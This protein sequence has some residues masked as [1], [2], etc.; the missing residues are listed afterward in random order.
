MI[1][2]RIFRRDGRP[3]YEAQWEDPTSGRK[4]TRTTGTPNRR[5]AE[6]FAAKLQL[7]L[8]SG[9]Y[10]DP[11][12]TGW[13]D[14]QALYKLEVFPAQAASTRRKM[15]DTFSAITRTIN[16]LRL[17][18]I[19][20]DQIALLCNALRLAGRAEYTIKGH[21][22]NIRRF[23]RWAVRRKLIQHMPTFDVP[24]K[25]VPQMKGRAPTTE[26]FDRLI[27][28]VPKVVGNDVA[29]AWQRMLRGLWLSGLRLSEALS[30]HWTDDSRLA[31]DLSGKS[32][33]FRIQ[34]GAEKGRKFRL[35]PMTPDFHAFLMETPEA[36]RHGYVFNPTGIRLDQR[37]SM[38]WASK[39]IVEI[40]QKANVKV[41]EKRGG[42]IKFVSSHDL[43]RAFGFRW[44][45]RV[46]AP[47]LML[48]M[49]HDSIVTTLQFYIG[50]DANAASEE[51]W[52]A[53]ANEVA[54]TA[55]E[56]LDQPSP[57]PQ[58]SP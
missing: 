43:R 18:G 9:T 7:E 37:P 2:V 53:F 14:F 23:M 10:R 12:K 5:D 30:L 1:R 32:P 38:D 15:L 24:V 8:E 33:M 54:N 57:A 31:V 47:V 3:F 39:V 13:E 25:P 4:R 36:D 49:R 55:S 17:A 35:L 21:L 41:A 26:E 56:S 50:H 16:P 40:G 28:A 20:E 29:P 6:R 52:K 46:R 19:G 48:L 27:E 34:A 44:S 58:E 11:V 51:V 22:A 42:K 45:N